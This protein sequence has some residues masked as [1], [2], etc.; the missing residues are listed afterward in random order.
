MDAYDMSEGDNDTRRKVVRRVEEYFLKPELET[1]A[2]FDEFVVEMRRTQTALAECEEFIS[3]I[4]KLKLKY[5]A[6]DADRN[7][8]RAALKNVRILCMSLDASL[9][10]SDDPDVVIE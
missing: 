6:D 8:L 9:R 2:A 4:K 1:R 5:I 7:K 10:G 3:R